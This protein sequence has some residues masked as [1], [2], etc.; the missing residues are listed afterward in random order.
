MFS[1]EESM[2]TNN[3]G[4]EIKRA[5]KWMHFLYLERSKSLY[6]PTDLA[7]MFILGIHANALKQPSLFLKLNRLFRLLP[8]TIKLSSV[9]L[10][11]RSDSCQTRPYL[12]RTA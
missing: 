5:I 8:H 4:A 11:L 1:M 9:L 7:F 10:G 2:S 12:L 6:K 3:K